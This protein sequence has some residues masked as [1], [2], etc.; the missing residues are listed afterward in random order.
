MQPLP[1]HRSRILRG[2]E[3]VCVADVASKDLSDD[4]PVD[5]ITD[6]RPSLSLDVNSLLKCRV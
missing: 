5:L 1:E 6:T 3:R 4:S 2:C